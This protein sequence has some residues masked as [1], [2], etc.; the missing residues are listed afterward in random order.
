LTDLRRI[1]AARIDSPEIR[2]IQLARI[3][4][5]GHSFEEIIAAVAEA[6][7]TYFQPTVIIAHTIPAKAWTLWKTIISGIQKPFKPGEAQKA[8]AELRTLRA[9]YRRIPITKN[10]TMKIV[11]IVLAIGTTISSSI[12]YPCI[13]HFIRSRW[14]PSIPIIPLRRFPAA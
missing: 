14:L 7:A 13:K 8:L 10:N 6:K 9:R 11:N 12:D 1:H 5:D 3:E 4:I 2:I